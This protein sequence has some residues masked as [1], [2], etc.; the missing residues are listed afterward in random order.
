MVRV[1]VRVR[2]CVFSDVLHSGDQHKHYSCQVRTF[3]G[4]KNMLKYV[5]DVEES[6]YTR[7][8]RFT[9]AYLLG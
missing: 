7:K 8:H 1:I 3:W 5:N 4:K 2:A 6:R 9:H